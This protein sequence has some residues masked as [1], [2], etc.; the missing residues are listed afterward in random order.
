MRSILTKDDK[1]TTKKKKDD[2]GPIQEDVAITEVENIAAV[3]EEVVEEGEKKEI[4]EPQNDDVV[5]DVAA[6][7]QVTLNVATKETDIPSTTRSHSRSSI[8]STVDLTGNWTLLTPSTFTSQYDN[9]LRQLGQPLLVRTVASTVIGTT[10]EETIQTDN[11]RKLYIRGMNVRGSWERTLHA[12]EQIIDDDTSITTNTTYNG[13]PIVQGHE[14]TPMTTADGEHVNVAS[15]WEENGTVHHSWVVG[16]QK[17]GGGDFENKRYL[18]D[19]GNILVCESTFHP[20]EE[21]GHN[22]GESIKDGK[23]KERKREKACVT[24]RF[25]REGAIVRYLLA[26]LYRVVVSAHLY[27]YMLCTHP[28]LFL[29]IF[30]VSMGILQR[31]FPTSLTY[32]KRMRRADHRLM[33]MILPPKIASHNM[34][35]LEI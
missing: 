19:G 10:K 6:D 16:G 4:T 32:L 31:N 33:M 23:K 29:T 27:S 18:T 14:L 22:G 21:D 11:G 9:Y 5:A 15:W 17:Y 20:R 8:T 2:E 13:H 30:C 1:D 34:F 12:S 25:L 26:V 7:E 3:E 35:S 24:W 28:L